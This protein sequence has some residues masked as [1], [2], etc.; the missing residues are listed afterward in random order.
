M[1]LNAYAR[2]TIN[3]QALQGDTSVQAM[4]SVDVSSDHIEVSELRWGSA[5]PAA[6]SGGRTGRAEMLPVLITKRIDQTTPRLYEALV[7]NSQVEGEIKIFDTDPN[8]GTTRHRFTLVLGRGRLQSVTSSSPDTL[9]PAFSARPPREVVA[10]TATS[11]T[12]R[13]EIHSVEYQ[14]E[15]SL[16]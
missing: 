2:L 6:A 3:G 15:S 10:I 13:D 7:K 5:V 14:Q 16:R 1:A 12:Y 8:D 11:L 9:D 4:G